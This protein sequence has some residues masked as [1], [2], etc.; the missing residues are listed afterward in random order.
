MNQK[1]V[2]IVGLTIGDPWDIHNWSN[3]PYN[4]FSK[5]QEKGYLQDAIGVKFKTLDKVFK[6]L[7]GIKLKRKSRLS[8]VAIRS[9]YRRILLGLEALIKLKTKGLPSNSFLA[10]LSTTT[11][12]DTRRIEFPKFVYIDATFSQAYALNP[13]YKNLNLIPANLFNKINEIERKI[14]NSYNGIF[15]FSEWVKTSLVNDYGINPEKITVVGYGANLPNV[16]DFNKIDFEKSILLSVVTDFYRKG[17]E[18]TVEA[19]QILKSQFPELKLVLV[20]N[21][22]KVIFERKKEGIKV[23]GFLKKD[24]FEDLQ[25]LISLY[26]SA[27]VFI[28]PSYYDTMPNVILEAMYLKTPVVTSNVCGIPE[29]VKDGETGFIVDSF[30]PEDYAE[31]VAVLLKNQQ[32][33]WSMGENARR[34][35]LE[36]F[37]WDVV[38]S[39]MIETIS[40]TV[41]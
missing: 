34:R 10:L 27:A 33:R 11:L 24:N 15:T 32:L 26:K 7:Y 2:K 20:G 36:R 38:I 41:S 1:Q 29:M 28:L 40:K 23:I 3:I 4:L 22:P 39:K 19:Y 6:L 12:I 13:N 17:G 5:L 30:N 31:K 35:V 37:T 25:K 8:E 18:I 21:I 14:L 16:D 9:N